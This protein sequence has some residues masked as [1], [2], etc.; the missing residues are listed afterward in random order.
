MRLRADSARAKPR[1]AHVLFD[2][3]KINTMTL[4]TARGGVAARR[5]SPQRRKGAKKPNPSP[6]SFSDV[7]EELLRAKARR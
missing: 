6:R 3:V 5:G 2:N 7:A 4:A 1:A